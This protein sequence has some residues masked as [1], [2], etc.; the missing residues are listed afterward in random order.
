M[1]Q[2][3]KIEMTGQIKENKVTALVKLCINVTINIYVI[4]INITYITL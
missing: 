1:S 3:E 2:R 4:Y